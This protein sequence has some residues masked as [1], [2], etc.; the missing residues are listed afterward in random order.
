[1]PRTELQG[2]ILAFIGERLRALGSPP[3]L[4]EIA[5]RFRLPAASSAAYHVRRL[6]DAGLLTRRPGA[7]GLLPAESPFALPI[8]G[9]A[10][11]GSGVIAQEDVEGRLEVGADLARGAEYLLRVKGESMTGAGILEGDLVQVR[12]QPAGSD[13][14]IVVALVGEEAV[15]KRLRHRGGGWTLVSEH[16]A[17]API[18]EGFQVIGKVTGVLRRYGG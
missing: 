14:E 7:R 3:T 4:R 16:P 11:A 1:M 17:Y 13:G 10:A 15:I 9:R 12:R 5:A 18:E 2:R 8:L 6:E